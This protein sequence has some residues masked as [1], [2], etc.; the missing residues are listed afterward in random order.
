M[1]LPFSLLEKI[2]H[3]FSDKLEIGRGGFAVVYKAMLENEVVAIKRL[4]N[5]YMYEREFQREV[6]CLIKMYNK[7]CFALS[8]YL[9]GVLMHILQIHLENLNGES[10]TKCFEEN[11]TRAVTN[12]VCGTL[13]YL[14]PEFY[15]G[16]ITHKFDLYSL[17]VIIIELLTGKKGYQT[18]ENVL[19]I[20]SNE[21]LDTLQ[22]EQIRVCA[23]IGIECT[24]ADPAKRPASMKHIIIRLA[25]LECSAHVIP[26]GG[27][28]DLLLLHQFVLCFPFEPNKV[29]TCPLEL[30][31]NTDN[32]VAFRLMDKSMGSSFLGL[33]LYGLVPPNT[34][35]TLI[36][37]TQEKEDQPRKY[38]ID[39]ILHAA[40]LI[41]G[42]DEHINTFQSQPDK[43][44]QDMGVAVQEVKL[45]ALYSQPPHITTLSSK[46][47]FEVIP[48]QTLTIALLNQ[49]I[50][51]KKNPND[52]HVC[53]LDTNQTKHWIIIGDNGGHVRIW[54]YQKQACSTPIFIKTLR[55]AIKC[56]KFIARKQ[57]I[58]AGTNHGIIYVYD[59][60]KMH[61][62]ASFKVGGRS[63]KL[64]S[65]AVHPTKPYLLSA[66]TQMKLWDWDK[67]WECVQT[68]EQ[69][70]TEFPIAFNPNDTFA[71]GSYHYHVKVWSLD[72]P[73]SNYDLFGHWGRVNCL[74]FFTCH[75]QE[76]LVTGSNDKTVKI[77]YLQNR[78]CAYTLEVFVSPVTSV[79]YQP[80]LETLITGSKDGAVYLWTTVNCRI[81]SCPPMLKR[82]IKTGCVGAVYHL[83]CVM[84]RIVIGKQNAVSIMDI[85]NMN[86]QERSTDYGEQQLSTDRRQQAGD[87][88][89]KDITGSISKLHILDVHPPELRFP[90]CPNEPIPCSLHLTNNTDEN[91]GFRLVDKSGTSPWCFTKLPLYGIVSCRSTCTLIVTMKEEMKQKEATDFDL[92]I[93]S[94]ILRDKHISLFKDQSESDQFFEEAKEFVNMMH[95]VALKA[96]YEKDVE[97]ASEDILVK[98]N[99][100]NYPMNSFK[101][102]DYAVICVKF[103]ARRKWIVAVTLLGDLHVY[104]CACVTKIEKIRSVEPGGIMIT[105]ILAVHPTLPYVLSLDTVLLDWD[106]SWKCTE[107]FLDDLT[108]VKFNPR[109][110]NSFASGSL[111]GD[112]KV[113]RLDSPVSEYSL[114]GHMDVVNCLDFITHGDEQ[115]LITGS[116]DCT[117]KIWDLQKRECIHTLEATSPV[118]CVL[119]H[120]NLPVLITGTAHGIVQ[121]WSSTNFRLKGTINLGGGGPVVGLTCLS[122]SPRI[123]IGQKNA[124]VTMEP[125]QSW[126]LTLDAEESIAF[127]GIEDPVIGRGVNVMTTTKHRSDK[128][129]GV[130]P[131]Q[132]KRKRVST[133]AS[134]Y[135]EAT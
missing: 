34:P 74:V 38:I 71:T 96:V 23:E 17:G 82:I 3:N 91:V 72:S 118:L 63:A 114:L 1:A 29:I 58:V 64:W 39:V 79:I 47:I 102:S 113:W 77:W 84:G 133:S 111:D 78:I 70:A 67:G 65:L 119:V 52:S 33:P 66:G 124:I 98:Y 109:E 117:A 28:N 130:G 122:G 18:V 90:Y 94:N 27:T 16:E 56:A 59:Y 22:W 108:T 75:D 37:T 53:S 12:N 116:E 48:G 100:D 57:W 73:R 107:T 54:D 25:E 35:Y 132:S 8:I 2:T 61:K 120:P 24:E 9:K 95:E 125:C 13:G 6:E 89:S 110:A 26:A 99:P 123:V 128:E 60:D 32:H 93:Q 76:F 97:V 69:S 30:T 21:M 121:V 104:D 51:C 31:N 103:I 20:W 44:F 127:F 88:M 105:P 10:A 43:F 83:A 36:V 41:L 40:T 129:G 42:D 106:L 86:Y 49:I 68:F 19:E 115:S 50:L 134:T 46:L 15:R 5:T 14:A 87:T 11:Q 101:V 7:D 92:V 112:V 45:K 85:D 81:H 62:I 4:S 80:N 131:T 55:M 135:Q 126:G